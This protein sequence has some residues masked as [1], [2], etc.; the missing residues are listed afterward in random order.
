MYEL[1]HKLM[2]YELVADGIDG[3]LEAGVFKYLNT[4][5]EIL[6]KLNDIVDNL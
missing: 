5:E 4:S 3:I 2:I 6:S 1:L